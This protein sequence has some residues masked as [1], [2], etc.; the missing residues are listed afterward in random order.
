VLVLQISMLAY[1]C[2]V[3]PFL[4]LGLQVS[5]TACHSLECILF[6]CA[7]ALTSSAL[8]AAVVFGLQWCMI[9]KWLNKSYIYVH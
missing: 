2:I 1:I 5:E 8:P 4:D 3:R 6:A 9:G 7:L